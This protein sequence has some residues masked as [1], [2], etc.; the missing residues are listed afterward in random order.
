MNI[1][2]DLGGSH[3]GVG[4]VNKNGKIIS[5]KEK[6][7]KLI[8]KN[9]IE[10]DIKKSIINNINQ[11][12]QEQNIKI[13]QIEMIGIACPGIISKDTII[14]A[15]NLGIKNFSIGNIIN[16]HYNIP[17]YLKNDAKCA[18]IAEKEYGCLKTYKDVVF[19]TIGTGIGGA[20]FYEGQLVQDQI[21]QTFEIGHMIIQKNGEQCNCG[22]KGCFE[23]Y[24]SIRAL[25]NIVQ[26]KYK[27]Q[28]EITGLELYNYI[29]E[30]RDDEKM[31]NII[32]EY[33]ENLIVG[34]SNIMVM[35]KTEAI[36]FGGSFVYYKDLFLETIE[37]KIKQLDLYVPN[38]EIAQ[39]KNDAGI[40][41]ASIIDVYKRR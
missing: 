30:N 24:S 33:I 12:L 26:E 35:Y 4:L 23:R 13:D 6:D 38:L 10:H 3:V 28:N 9:E 5:K 27:I 41:G 20:I 2:I 39:M 19:L 37:E 14:S 36:G 34:L 22:K 25:K 7:I 16:K 40:I 1:G 18:A 31:Q 32:D 21:S 15:P 29:L 11:L 8:N 17:V